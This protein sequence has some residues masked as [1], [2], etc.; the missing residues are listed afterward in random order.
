[1]DLMLPPWIYSAKVAMRY[2]A[3]EGVSMPA[4]GGPVRVAGFGGDRWGLGLTLSTIDVASAEGLRD[5]RAAVSFLSRL[6][7]RQNRAFITNP[8]QLT[9]GSFTT[10][11][12]LSN[13][14]FNSLS[15]WTIASGFDGSASGRRI[16]LTRS[17][18]TGAAVGALRP[19]NAI[20]VTAGRPYVLRAMVLPGRGAATGFRLNVGSSAFASDYYS[21]TGLDAGMLTL[22]FVPYASTVHVSLGQGIVDAVAGDYFEVVYMS[23]AQCALLDDGQNYLP[24]TD[25]S[26]TQWTK[27]NSSISST[28]VVLPDG[29]S[30]IVNTIKE[31]ATAA[32]S[33]FIGE[34]V[35]IATDVRDW[36]FGVALKKTANRNWAQIRLRDETSAHH[37]NQSINL[38]TGALG[39]MSSDAASWQNPQGFVAN[40][41]NGWWEVFVSGR[42]TTGNIDLGVRI[43]VG[44]ADADTTFTGLNQDSIHVWRP[45]LAQSSVPMQLVETTGSA[46]ESGTPQRGQ[47]VRLKGL[48]PV[49]TN[50]LRLHSQELELVTAWD[51]DPYSEIKRLVGDLNSDAVGRA[52]VS[53][54]PALRG[55][56][57]DGNAVIFHQP[58]GCFRSVEDAP[59]WDDEPGAL[60]AS[61]QSEEA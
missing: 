40:A 21:A 55:V 26:Q 39:A 23:L 43:L 36:C 56:T 15:G 44:E 27:G 8:R 41:G 49:S 17:S 58:F 53:I 54:E 60:M 34:N 30:G 29:T 42:M 51:S 37:V 48:Y 50:G 14:N 59:G 4:F 61:R 46:L 22:A 57:A 32:T 9:G 16:R 45:T 28:S 38:D 13:T 18:N 12:L 25:I 5:Y 52:G 10:N 7:G 24:I 1:M 6:R 33:H 3:N 35:T 2:L 20:S 31:D 47:T 11:E 19:D